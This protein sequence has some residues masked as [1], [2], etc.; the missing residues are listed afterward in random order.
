MTYV[1]GRMHVKLKKYKTIHRTPIYISMLISQK[2]DT[3]NVILQ[4]RERKKKQEDN[5]DVSFFY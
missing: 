3:K 4:R 2:K 5:E 1:K